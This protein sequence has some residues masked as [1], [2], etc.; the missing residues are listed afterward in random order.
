M[1]LDYEQLSREALMSHCDALEL[2]VEQLNG[3]LA[4]RGNELQTIADLLSRMETP[5]QTHW[6]ILYPDGRGSLHGGLEV[7][8]G[9]TWPGPADAIP[10]L[11]KFVSERCLPTVEEAIAAFDALNNDDGLSR[12]ETRRWIDTVRRYLE[13]QSQKPGQAAN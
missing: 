10:S 9:I 2:E 6:V 11:R 4:E 1:N 3:Q 7:A 5:E 12:N 13:S 8:T